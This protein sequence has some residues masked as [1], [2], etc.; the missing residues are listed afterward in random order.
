MFDQILDK[1]P[2]SVVSDKIYNSSIDEIDSQLNKEFKT[3]DDFYSILS[4]SADS[5]LEELAKVS[6]N[7]TRMRFGNTIQLYAPLYI[8]NECTNSCI[9]CGFNMRHKI[10]RITLSYDMIEEESEILFRKGFRHILLVSGEH[11]GVVP[12][13]MLSEIGK[14]LHSKFA[15]ISIEVYPM[16]EDEY[17][18]MIGSGV[19]GLAIYQE[20]YD[21]EA[22]GRVHL[23]GQKKDFNW[24]LNAPE[25]GGS[26]GFRRIGIG[27]L[28]GI[29]DWRVEGFFLA[30]HAYY[31]MKKCWR[32][33]IQISFPRL[34]DAHVG[35]KAPKPVSDRDL[36]HLICAMRILNP[37]VGLVLSTR[38]LP[39]L[40]DNI[41]PLG[42][43][44]MSAG[45]KTEPGGYS[46][47]GIADEQFEIMDT[48]SPDTVATMIKQMG[49]D[50]V[51]K[52]WDRDFLA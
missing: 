16:K 37:D 15:S 21:R 18:L 26:A 10:K 50:P 29:S 31:L 1:Y 38:E 47:A 13:S 9:Y 22:Y 30:L 7:I 35:Y 46:H 6:S 41:L 23:S 28:L 36:V 32:S 8:S 20:T 3:P 39:L 5:Y 17:K 43:T 34:R 4:P 27:V 19:D 25:R 14:R 44:M 40:R 24:R 52:D 12:V 45:S 51:W 2:W 48:R 42:I 11:R 33:L 49:F